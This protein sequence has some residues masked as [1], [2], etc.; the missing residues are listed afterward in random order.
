MGGYQPW[1]SSVVET[2]YQDAGVGS[3]TAPRAGQ[4]ADRTEEE[5]MVD[6]V[7]LG[8]VSTSAYSPLG[9]TYAEMQGHLGVV[10]GIPA[11]LQMFLV[12]SRQGQAWLDL[13]RRRNL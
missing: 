11:R 8:T 2:A 9:F 12:A 13:R 7:V 5:E 3:G 6:L 1:A 4:A 10:A